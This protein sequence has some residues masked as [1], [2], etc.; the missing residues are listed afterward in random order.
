MYICMHTCLTF[1][2]YFCFLF[3]DKYHH[4]SYITPAGGKSKVFTLETNKNFSFPPSGILWEHQPSPRTHALVCSPLG[5]PRH[6]S[7]PPLQFSRLRDATSHSSASSSVVAPAAIC[8]RLTSM[9]EAE[10]NVCI[11]VLALVAIMSAQISSNF[12]VNASVTLPCI[13]KVLMSLWG[14]GWEM[15]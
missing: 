6:L 10:D 11:R 4:T 5:I 15:V 2:F 1:D 13:A 8:A 7:P 9:Q 12:S 3:L 14:L